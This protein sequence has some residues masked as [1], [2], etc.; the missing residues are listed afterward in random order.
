MAKRKRGRVRP[1]PKKQMTMLAKADHYLTAKEVAVFLK[2]S[3]SWVRHAT[4]AG[5]IPTKR[6]GAFCR[7][8]REEIIAFV[9]GTWK[10]KRG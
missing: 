6:F 2:V 5:E 1:E 9:D 8:A 4:A 7:Y 10:P 3:E